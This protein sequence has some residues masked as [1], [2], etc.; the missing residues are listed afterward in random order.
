MTLRNKLQALTA[1]SRE[2]DAEIAVMFQVPPVLMRHVD[3]LTVHPDGPHLIEVRTA[4]GSDLGGFAAI[5]FTSS[6]DAAVEL[7]EREL[8]GKNWSVVRYENRTTIACLGEGDRVI[9]DGRHSLPAVALLLA[10][11]EAKG[12]E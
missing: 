8:P 1:P 6:L 2:V 11:L 7:V 5:P 3:G 4:N 10:L 12:I 9:A